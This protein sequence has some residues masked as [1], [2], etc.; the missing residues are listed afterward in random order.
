MLAVRT[1]KVK[2]IEEFDYICMARM[3]RVLVAHAEQIVEFM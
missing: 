3:T 2:M 1:F